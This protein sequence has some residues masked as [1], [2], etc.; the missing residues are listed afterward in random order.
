[1]YYLPYREYK[2]ALRQQRAHD[3]VY[4]PK[5]SGDSSPQTTPVNNELSKRDGSPGNSYPQQP[6]ALMNL[7]NHVSC[8]PYNFCLVEYYA[9][10]CVVNSRS[11]L[12]HVIFLWLGCSPKQ[13]WISHTSEQD[14][15]TN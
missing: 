15:D 1:M 8:D 13:H 12:W 3:S 6:Q 5:M 14:R 2:E 10:I 11:N 7:T 4:R 9:V